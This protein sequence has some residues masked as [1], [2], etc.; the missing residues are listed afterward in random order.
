[1]RTI[2]R[3]IVSALLISKDG[4]IFFGRKDRDSGD[5]YAGCWHIPGGGVE[6]G[7]T[8]I[9]AL[10]REIFEETGIDISSY[11]S[12]LVDN[13]GTGTTEKVLKNKGEKVLCEMHFNVYSVNLNENADEIEVNLSSELSQ[14]QWVNLDKI[15]NVHKTPPG[16][17]FF[18]RFDTNKLKQ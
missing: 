17:E 11:I 9:I 16:E 3:E 5:T 14:Y 18:A 8:N 10:Q 2:Q 6:V 7:E 13:E 4:K 12:E 1:M 15:D